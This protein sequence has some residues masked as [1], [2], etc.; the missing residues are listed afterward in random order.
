V[1]V[2]AGYGDALGFDDVSL[3]VPERQPA[4]LG[5]SGVGK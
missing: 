3:A 4:V 5:R 1:N 2:T